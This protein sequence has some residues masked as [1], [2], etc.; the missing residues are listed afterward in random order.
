M[1]SEWIKNRETGIKKLNRNL[2]CDVLI[3][4]AGMSGLLCAYQ[5][6]DMFE[7]IVIIESDE[8]A[9]GASGRNTGKI[10]SQ[11]GLNY[12][13]ILKIH[14]EEKTRLYYQ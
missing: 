2:E 11:H 4:G 3:V 14:G 8:I 7:H 1:K 10:T 9:G 5:L 13:E 12:Q 6:Q